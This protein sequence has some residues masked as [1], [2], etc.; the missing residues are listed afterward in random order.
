MQGFR[1]EEGRPALGECPGDQLR[2]EPGVGLLPIPMRQKPEKGRKVVGFA[3]LGAG[4]GNDRGRV[5]AGNV[6]HNEAAMLG[7]NVRQGDNTNR[8][9]CGLNDL[10][11]VDNGDMAPIAPSNGTNEDS[12]RQLRRAEEGAHGGYSPKIAGQPP[13]KS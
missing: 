12:P 9:P 8:W 7:D 3:D 2:T 1:A 11:P 5:L 4:G 13:E 10:F 6:G